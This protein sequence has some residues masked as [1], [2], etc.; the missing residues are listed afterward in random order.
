[1]DKKLI[2][3]AIEKTLLGKKEVAAQL[4]PDNKFPEL[5]LN[6]VLNSNAN[7]DSNQLSKLAALAGCTVSEILGND[8]T[9]TADKSGLLVFQ[10]ERYRAELN[11]ETWT[12]R[13]FDNG[14]LFHDE[15]IHGQ[16]VPLS[17]YIGALNELVLNHKK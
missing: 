14:S 4:Y 11:T 7:L 13:I 2:L 17:E 16:G 15:I 1:M 10:S 5:A 12:T 3:T 6:R 9:K 8:W